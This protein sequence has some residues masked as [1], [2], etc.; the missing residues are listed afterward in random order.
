MGIV[1][2]GRL[3]GG[4]G[5]YVLMWRATLV[6]ILSAEFFLLP[7][8]RFCPSNQYHIT[9]DSILRGGIP[10]AEPFSKLQGLYELLLF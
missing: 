8:N 10:S 2:R 3:N 6:C 5:E 9:Y 4:V 1:Q 7:F